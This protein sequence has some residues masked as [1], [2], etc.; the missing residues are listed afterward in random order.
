MEA[1]FFPHAAAHA[2]KRDSIIK[3]IAPR[4]KGY[5]DA[6][7]SLWNGQSDRR[8]DQLSLM[9]HRLPRNVGWWWKRDVETAGQWSNWRWM[10]PWRSNLSAIFFHRQRWVSKVN[11]MA[12]TPSLLCH[13]IAL[14]SRYPLSC[15]HHWWCYSCCVQH[16][17]SSAILIPSLSPLTLLNLTF[18]WK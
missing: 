3:I 6:L 10:A 4:G 14:M 2:L 1:C 11:P 17:R 16:H 12:P 5:I 13:T 18:Y 9:Y 15:R 7:E 8:M